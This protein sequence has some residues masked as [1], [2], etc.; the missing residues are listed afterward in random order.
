MSAQG[1]WR[2][3]RLLVANPV[4]ADPN[5][6]RTVVLVL[7]HDSEGAVGVVLNRPSV[8]PVGMVAP[9]WESLCAEPALVHIGGPVQP[10]A[11][12]CLGR[13]GDGTGPDPGRDRPGVSHLFGTIGSVDLGREPDP[14]N[15]AVTAVRIFAGYSGWGS[16]QL[17]AEL[18]EGGWFVVRRDDSD[19]FSPRPEGLWRRVLARQRSS[20]V[21]LA[22]FPERPELN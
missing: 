14:E 21:M 6:K 10:E 16:G 12:I 15:P 8:A 19:P 1:P 13:L 2:S 20:L 4:I 9:R 17:E 3:G 11:A 5:F 22:N 18:A 7:Q